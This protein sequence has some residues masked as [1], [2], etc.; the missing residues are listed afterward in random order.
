MSNNNF[1]AHKVE[2]T[3]DKIYMAC[4]RLEFPLTGPAIYKVYGKWG[5]RGHTLK[6]QIKLTTGSLN[7][8][9]REQMTL[10][11]SKIG[12]GYV[13]IDS[14][15]YTGPVT[16]DTPEIKESMEPEFDLDGKIRIKVLKSREPV[17]PEIGDTVICINNI[18]MEDKFNM[19]IEYICEKH[20]DKNM[21]KVYDK[22]GVL[23][24]FFKDRFKGV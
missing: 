15:V 23:G 3:S 19:G 18:G 11:Q 7:I 4:I 5:R 12:E 14:D 24:D 8:A 17:L 1:I 9:M 21:L 6:G 13:D 20:P 2:G 10:F 22:N 16:R